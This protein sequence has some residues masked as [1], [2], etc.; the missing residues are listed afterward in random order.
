MRIAESDGVH[1][2]LELPV[3]SEPAL[4]DGRTALVTL[5]AAS[6]RGVVRMLGDAKQ[7]DG[8]TVR[9]RIADVLEVHQRRSWVR[10]PAPRPIV[11]DTDQGA[12]RI[13]SIALDFGGGGMLLAGPDFLEVGA[14]THFRL[15]LAR[16]GVPIEG[17]G[18]VVRV[19][20][21]GRRAIAFEGISDGDRDR[22]IG[23]IFERERAARKADRDG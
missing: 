5:E 11:L 21:Q 15:R 22:V 19:D 20:A 1:L 12:T 13:G 4:Q 6:P 2:T 3:E 18:R 23:F 14:R 16:D 17:H 8:A 9:F 10:F 7:L